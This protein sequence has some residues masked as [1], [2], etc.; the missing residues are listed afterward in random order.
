LRGNLDPADI[1]HVVRPPDHD[2]LAGFRDDTDIAGAKPTVGEM[3]FRALFIPEIAGGHARGPGQNDPRLADFLGQSG[4]V[5]DA[6]QDVRQQR[7]DP[8][9][10]G[11]CDVAGLVRGI[12]GDDLMG[13]AGPQ[14]GT[15]PRRQG[16]ADHPNGAAIGPLRHV[17][18]F[19]REPDRIAHDE[20]RMTGAMASYGRKKVFVRAIPHQLSIL[21]RQ[22][23]VAISAHLAEAVQ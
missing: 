15:Q 7:P 6:D 13:E 21:E 20:H 9:I 12:R 5:D 10:V 14:R 3:F 11:Q 17:R 22:H 16:R 23:R 19:R 8:V 4:I 18:R 1:E 2:E